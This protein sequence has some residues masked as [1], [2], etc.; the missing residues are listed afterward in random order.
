[1]DIEI[2]RPKQFQDII[3]SYYLY[4][5]GNKFIKIKPNSSQIVSIPSHTKYIQ[6]KID[7]CTSQKFYIDHSTCQKLI[8]K[9]RIGGNFFS[10]L[11]LPLHYMTSK[12]RYLKIE[13]YKQ[14]FKK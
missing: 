2:I 9:N 13:N 6:A 1:M 10:P 4:V 11:L 12:N 5:D 3:R 7:W 8:I 14:D